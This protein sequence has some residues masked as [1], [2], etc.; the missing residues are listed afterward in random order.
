MSSTQNCRP[1]A[2]APRRGSIIVIVIWAVAI[3]AVLIAQIY[4]K[5]QWRAIDSRQREQGSSLHDATISK[6]ESYHSFDVSG[7]AES[8][9]FFDC[10]ALRGRWYEVRRVCTYCIGIRETLKTKQRSVPLLT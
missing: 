10:R 2:T 7:Q 3:A 9:H 6:V 4:L 5:C 1:R 8:Y